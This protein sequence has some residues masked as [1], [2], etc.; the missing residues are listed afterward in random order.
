MYRFGSDKISSWSLQYIHRIA[1]YIKH[2]DI[3]MKYFWEVHGD[4]IYQY[5]F[6]MCLIRIGADLRSRKNHLGC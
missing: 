1:H 2:D 5:F 6:S 4:D 3:S